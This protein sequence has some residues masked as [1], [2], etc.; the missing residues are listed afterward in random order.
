[1]SFVRHNSVVM[2][3][4]SKVYTGLITSDLH[5]LVIRSD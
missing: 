1:M 3:N 5:S 2:Q 4:K